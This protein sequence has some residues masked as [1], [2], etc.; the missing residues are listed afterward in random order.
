[1]VSGDRSLLG[2][3]GGCDTRPGPSDGRA[4]GT[5]LFEVNENKIRITAAHPVTC[6]SLVD[7]VVNLLTADPSLTVILAGLLL[8][9]FG[10]YFF[11]RRLLVKSARSYREGRGGR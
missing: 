11:L 5:V 7:T 2:S 9:V 1:M 4:Y 10:G 6:M 8:L 3:G